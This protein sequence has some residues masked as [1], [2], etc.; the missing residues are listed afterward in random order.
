MLGHDIVPHTDIS[1]GDNI[2]FSSNSTS[3]SEQIANKHSELGH[4]FE[5]F[6]H[7]YSNSTL[8]YISGNINNFN[9]KNKILQDAVLIVDI[10]DQFTWHTNFEKQRFRDYPIIPYFST[11]SSHTLRGPPSC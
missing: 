3:G 1:K 9:F 5:H 8:K 2:S 4:I 11:L 7:S 10:D 6:Q